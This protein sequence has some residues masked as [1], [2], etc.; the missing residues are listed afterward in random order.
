MY[1]YIYIY[2][3]IYTYIIRIYNTYVVVS[4]K[5]NNPITSTGPSS[6]VGIKGH[7]TM[8]EHCWRR[9]DTLFVWKQKDSESPRKPVR[10]FL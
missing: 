10:F 3:F 5:R 6:P 9:H 7:V 4:K 1:V 8:I 2:I